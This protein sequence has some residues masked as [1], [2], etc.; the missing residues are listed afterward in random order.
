MVD[1]APLFTLRRLFGALVVFS[2]LRFLFYG[3][4]DCQILEPLYTF[5]FEEFD[6]LPRP[7]KL[8]TFALFSGMILGGL[9]IMTG[10]LFR[11]GAA[12]FFLC[13]TYVEVLDKTNYLNHY[14]F[15]SLLSLLLLFSNAHKENSK[16]PAFQLNLFRVMIG[17]VYFYGIFLTLSAF[18]PSTQICYHRRAFK[19]SHCICK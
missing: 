14:Y 13:F 17:I 15:V 11:V 3:W 18:G 19:Y 2:T 5:P 16:L 6:F 8:G 7:N 4:H 12:L 1:S 9:S 10:K